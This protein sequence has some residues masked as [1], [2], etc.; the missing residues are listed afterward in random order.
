MKSHVECKWKCHQKNNCYNQNLHKSDYNIF[1]NQGPFIEEVE[2][3]DPCKE[4]GQH[5]YLPKP[6]CRAKAFITEWKRKANGEDVHRNFQIVSGFDKYFKWR[7]FWRHILILR[8]FLLW[9]VF[10]Q[11]RTSMSK[12]MNWQISMKRRMHAKMI[13]HTPAITV[14]SC[15]S[16]EKCVYTSV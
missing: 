12:L 11:F 15:L 10:L 2:K 4:N 16:G 14:I 8:G 3:I 5:S 1:P 13:V 6:M 7:Y 9:F